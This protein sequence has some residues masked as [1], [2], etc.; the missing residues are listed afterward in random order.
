MNRH[1]N[2]YND[3]GTRLYPKQQTELDKVIIQIL[4]SIKYRVIKPFLNDG[5]KPHIG[6][7][8]LEKLKDYYQKDQ[9]QVE[10]NFGLSLT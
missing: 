9:L 1:R 5:V 8:S 10:Q 3:A 2:I 7:S 6:N 4:E